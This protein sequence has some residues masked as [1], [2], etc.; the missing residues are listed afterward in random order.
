MLNF[1]WILYLKISIKFSICWCLCLF[2]ALNHCKEFPYKQHIHFTFYFI[3]HLDLSLQKCRD[4][5]KNDCNISKFNAIHLISYLKLNVCTSVPYWLFI[6]TIY[7]GEITKLQKKC[8]CIQIF[9]HLTAYVKRRE[10]K[11]Y[12][13]KKRPS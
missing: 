13:I 9:M 12:S 3:V 2:H 5:E 1:T 7:C 6:F 11:T 10:S 8:I 4:Y